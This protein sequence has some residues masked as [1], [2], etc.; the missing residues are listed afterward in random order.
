VGPLVIIIVLFFMSYGPLQWSATPALRRHIGPGFVI[1][2]LGP[3]ILGLILPKAPVFLGIVFILFMTTT[4]DRLDAGCR[5]ILLSLLLPQIIWRINIGSFYLL[6]ITTIEV[7]A[8]AT[9]IQCAA[10]P[11]PRV[12]PM[13]QWTAEDWFVILTFVILWIGGGRMPSTSMFLREALS[14][15]LLIVIPYVTLRRSLRSSDEF[16]RGI[17]CL[18]VAC[19]ILA[20]FAIYESLNGWTLFGSYRHVSDAAGMN[21]GLIQRGGALRAPATM[22]SALMLGVVLLAGLTAALYS[23]RYVRQG[24]MLMGWVTVIFL[25]L[26][27]TQSRGNTALL[28]VAVLIFC[29]LRKKYGYAALIGIGAP[30]AFGILMAA[31]RVSPQIAAFL[32]VGGQGATSQLTADVYDYRELLFTRGMEEAAKH[33]W[34]GASYDYVVGQLADIAQGQGIVDM[35]NTYLT[36][37]LI[38]G[39]AGMIPFVALLGTIWWKLISARTDRGGTPELIDMRGFALAALAVVTV[40]LAFMSFIDRLPLILGLAL[41]GARMVAIELR[42]RKR[43]SAAPGSE[44]PAAAPARPIRA[45]RRPGMPAPSQG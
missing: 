26:M 16:V 29:L 27:M 4:R 12:A 24:W 31:A 7:L 23:R 43:T 42:R 25:G 37:Y 5:F 20:L 32:N 18:A 6:D 28:P 2:Y 30:A 34:T 13:P 8:V 44:A 10:K 45:T 19:G 15:L 17:A 35:V 21:K 3:L 33:R 9:L 38:S 39:L 41:V 14:Q 11:G 40:Q 1:S 36:F 22:S